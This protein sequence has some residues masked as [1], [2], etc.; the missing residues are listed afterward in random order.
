[1]WLHLWQQLFCQ[2]I[3]NPFFPIDFKEIAEHLYIKVTGKITTLF[4]IE[5]IKIKS[6]GSSSVL[7]SLHL[8]E[9]TTLS[10]SLN[11]FG[12]LC[13]L[14]WLVASTSKLLSCLLHFTQQFLKVTACDFSWASSIWD[15]NFGSKE[16]NLTVW[17]PSVSCES[18]GQQK[19]LQHQQ[20]CRVQDQRPW[21]V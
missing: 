20:R 2:P 18:K 11:F 4:R 8:A 10:S 19:L 7:S 3:E 14:V 13:I 9:L 5:K 6:S 15:H 12:E 1:M 17:R 16:T 21:H